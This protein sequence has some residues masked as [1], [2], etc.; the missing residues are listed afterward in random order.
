MDELI[1][2]LECELTD[3]EVR[4]AAAPSVLSRAWVLED[5]KV[6]AFGVSLGLAREAQRRMAGREPAWDIVP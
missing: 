3:A 1:R 4:R 2:K 5:G 6:Q